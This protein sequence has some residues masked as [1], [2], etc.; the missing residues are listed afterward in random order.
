MKDSRADDRIARDTI[1][2]SSVELNVPVK[3]HQ[4]RATK[5]RVDTYIV[6][7]PREG[8][9]TRLA[10]IRILLLEAGVC[11][12]AGKG[13]VKA[14]RLSVRVGRCRRV[15]VRQSP[16]KR[17]LGLLASPRGELEECEL[18]SWARR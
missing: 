4:R 15:G 17:V 12:E 3:I 6:Q 11:V 14:P 13:I 5:Q 18:L 10:P 9:S 7:L 8:L 1:C 16:V 2:W